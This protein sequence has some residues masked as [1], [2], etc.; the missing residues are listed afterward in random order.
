[1][2]MCVYTGTNVRKFYCIFKCALFKRL[3]PSRRVDSSILHRPA[4]KYTRQKKTLHSSALPGFLTATAGS[5]ERTR[6]FNAPRNSGAAVSDP[7]ASRELLVV[8]RGGQALLPGRVHGSPLY[9]HAPVRQ[10]MSPSIRFPPCPHQKLGLNHS[11]YDAEHTTYIS[12]TYGPGVS[13]E[14]RNM[15]Y[16]FKF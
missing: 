10:P 16:A 15:R 13:Q 9:L 8:G 5:G 14:L 1:M 4:Y 2:N 3:Y 12:A 6:V 7:P 11:S